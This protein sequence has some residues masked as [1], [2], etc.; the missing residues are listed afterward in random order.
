M[1]EPPPAPPPPP[2][3][4]E[5]ET[6][7]V[8]KPEDAKEPSLKEQEK[9]GPESSEFSHDMAAREQSRAVAEAA[10]NDMAHIK[11]RDCLGRVFVF[12]WESVK[13][14][15]NMRLAI[16]AV[17][18][19][20]SLAWPLRDAI[21]CGRYDLVEP[22][23][24]T[25]LPAYWDTLVRPGM[26]II[27]R[28]QNP[29]GADFVG[30]GVPPAAPGYAGPAHPGM[31]QAGM[32]N[33]FQSS[34]RPGFPF[35]DP[36]RP[37]RRHSPEI[38]EV[39][40]RK[41]PRRPVLGWMADRTSAESGDKRRT[42]RRYGG[43]ASS[44]SGSSSTSSQSDS[45]AQSDTDV[46][47][48][49]YPSTAARKKLVSRGLVYS[50]KF[51][52]D[53]MVDLKPGLNRQY[54]FELE[55]GKNRGLN[56]S[57]FDIVSANRFSHGI[58]DIEKGAASVQ[59]VH[60]PKNS[61][62]SSNGSVDN[63]IIMSWHHIKRRYMDFE[64]FS[65]Y[66]CRDLSSDSNSM[67]SIIRSLMGRARR[68]K[69]RRTDYGCYI[70]PGTIM[71]WDGSSDN[72]DEYAI[73]AAVPYLYVD[74][75]QGS[76]AEKVN[77]KAGSICPPWRLH[78]SFSP[79]DPSLQRD[80]EQAFRKYQG[81]KG[82]Q[83]FWVGQLWVLITNSGFLTSGDMSHNSDWLMGDS[84]TT[85]LEKPHGVLGERMVE[86]MDVQRQIF[87]ISLD[88]CRTFVQLQ[89]TIIDELTKAYAEPDIGWDWQ[90]VTPNHREL[91]AASWQSM[92]KD[93]KNRVLRVSFE[94]K[95][96]V[97]KRRKRT[98]SS[99]SSR[100]GSHNGTESDSSDEDSVTGAKKPEDAFF[101]R[102]STD[103]GSKDRDEEEN[104][105]VDPD[106]IDADISFSLPV[107]NRKV[108]PFLAWPEDRKRHKG[109]TA[110]RNDDHVKTL[111]ES[112][113]HVSLAMNSTTHNVL[114]ED[115]V[116]TTFSQEESDVPA[117]YH[118]SPC[119]S[120]EDLCRRAKG[121]GLSETTMPRAEEQNQTLAPPRTTKGRLVSL[122][123]AE[124]ILQAS[125]QVLEF[126]APKDSSSSVIGKFRGGLQSILEVSTN[127]DVT[128]GS[129]DS[130]ISSALTAFS[131]AR[132]AVAGPSKA[133]TGSSPDDGKPTK[134][135]I[136]Q[137]GQ[138]ELQATLK[139]CMSCAEGKVYKTD[140]A[141]IDHLRGETHD[142]TF[143]SRNHLRNQFLKPL[144]EAVKEKQQAA[145]LKI[146]RLCRD[147]ML[148]IANQASILQAGVAS[149][150]GF[151][152]P[153]LPLSLIVAFEMVVFFLCSV[154]HS[155]RHLDRTIEER[156]VSSEQLAGAIQPSLMR[157]L[158]ETLG[159]KAEALVLKANRLII[160]SARTG[161]TGDA[162]H[163]SKRVGPEYVAVQAICNLL[164]RPVHGGM[165]AAGLYQG[166][167]DKQRSDIL[168]HS[169]GRKRLRT[170]LA[171]ADETT[172][173]ATITKH[174]Q[175]LITTLTTLLSPATLP[176]HDKAHG[177]TATARKVLYKLEHALLHTYSQPLRTRHAALT[178][179]AQRDCKAME[180][181]I[182]ECAELTK[183]EHSRAPSC[184]SPSPRSSSCRSAS[185]RRISA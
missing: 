33:M 84:I 181:T 105:W 116:S 113:E 73:F 102:V 35:G 66:A 132:T 109:N 135:V 157:M 99:I 117:H 108:P 106:A 88:R 160:T 42:W 97:E 67:F 1:S 17:F 58:S 57:S 50:T 95:K 54:N 129:S 32:M 62:G 69:L 101:V 43:S 122:V 2:E 78:Q 94:P 7:Q 149:D 150:E 164:S 38:I 163:Y 140:D 13:I 107:R 5:D 28:M 53:D 60:R 16:G 168:T 93:E 75:V 174:Q 125:I 8:D 118:Q 100:G 24:G 40:P 144:S 47:S 87:Y 68:E 70:E 15:M 22:T 18:R 126:F 82:S 85:D 158:E 145:K 111:A 41:R 115:F 19:D 131:S 25:I 51:N 180:K 146:L 92:V 151:R 177:R 21:R 37:V 161:S 130:S 80:E 119:I 141:A 178:K 72:A 154:G 147:Q 121:L 83:I 166:Y 20:F 98:G 14:W 10:L 162:V 127:N 91:T 27:M 169:P 12:P 114:L 143:P 36:R 182:V 74:H 56:L 59:L 148:R 81:K 77:W 138:K 23:L 136:E 86:F 89:S 152:S 6:G 48:E 128:T 176:K 65:H 171:L 156:I 155:L 63:D 179:L 55:G 183:D 170:I 34:P 90:L 9:F 61:R 112:L 185:S 123:I 165:D 134:W 159:N 26:A 46:D 76:T 173:L 142:F 137:S 49:Q 3:K 110:F 71:R 184:S 167:I 139:D 30:F 11:F 44:G 39:L 120:Y 29:N 104:S 96:V 103:M 124:Q 79:F 175:T 45:D 153:G 133:A 52:K 4:V 172:L 64:E 31:G